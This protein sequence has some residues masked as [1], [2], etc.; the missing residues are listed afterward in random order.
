MS[1]LHA[2]PRPTRIAFRLLAAFRQA[3][4][5]VR[6][7]CSLSQL[8]GPLPHQ[9]HYWTATI[10][11]HYDFDS[12]ARWPRERPERRG[13]DRE[14]ARFHLLPRRPLCGHDCHQRDL[15]ER[16]ISAFGQQCVLA[17]P[18]VLHRCRLPWSGN[19]KP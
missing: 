5:W 2:A 10:T 6:S 1:I 13:P 14:F 7:W 16:L 9:P 19:P 12:P 3:P 18:Y 8:V 15:Q 4:E 11:L 17:E